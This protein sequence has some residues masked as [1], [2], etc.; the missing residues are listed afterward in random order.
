VVIYF[1]G[2]MG[3]QVKKLKQRK[4]GFGEFQ[5]ALSDTLEAIIRSVRPTVKALLETLIGPCGMGKGKRTPHFPGSPMPPI[6]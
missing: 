2:V 3:K 1:T 5:Q 4:L 6:E